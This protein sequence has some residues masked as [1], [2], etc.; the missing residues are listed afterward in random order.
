VYLPSKSDTQNR[1]DGNDAR[2]TARV[3]ACRKPGRSAALR[4]EPEGTPN[5]QSNNQSVSEGTL[6][7]KKGDISN[8]V[9]E[10]KFLKSLD[11]YEK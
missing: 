11:K 3:D 6:L 4:L 7:I 9:R 2:K 5:P 10:G 1:T 8:E